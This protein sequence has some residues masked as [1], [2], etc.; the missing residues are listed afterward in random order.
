MFSS[1]SR[2][3]AGGEA[4]EVQNIVGF[5]D[6]GGLEMWANSKIRECNPANNQQGNRDLSL[7]TAGK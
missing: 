5:E 1:E 2:D 7:T 3:E 4:K 6:E